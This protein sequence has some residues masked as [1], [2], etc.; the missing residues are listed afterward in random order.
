MNENWAN[1]G[2]IYTRRWV[3]DTL[4][5]L[6]SYSPNADLGAKLIVEPSVG[7]GAFLEGIVERLF[8]SARGHNRDLTSLGSSI[9]AFDLLPESVKKAL[10]QRTSVPLRAFFS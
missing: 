2:E 1:Y 8:A 10:D 4:L 5:D 3:V 7:S 6:I 9:R